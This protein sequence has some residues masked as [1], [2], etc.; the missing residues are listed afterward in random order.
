MIYLIL[1]CVLAYLLGSVPTSVWVGKWFYHI[2]IREHGSGNAGATNTLRVLGAKVALPVFLFDVF[3]GFLMPFL[4]HHFINKFPAISDVYL[5]PILIGFMAVIG[6]IYPLFAGFR[7]GK[8]VATLLGMMLGI[9]TLPSLLS[10]GV[11]I[12]VLI[13]TK[14]VSVGSLTA[15]L[16]F[17]V[18]TYFFVNFTISLMIFSIIA[19]ILLFYTHRKNIQRLI[20]GTESKTTFK[21]KN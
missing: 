13:A 7:G 10:F 21:K 1:F 14:Y 17:P 9:A 5:F 11:F 12:I 8:G 20:N 18:F 4:A 2:D 3:K 16:L 19:C 6:H 15:G